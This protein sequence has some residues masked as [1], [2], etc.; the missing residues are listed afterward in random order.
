MG[1]RMRDTDRGWQK[2]KA[3]IK[4]LR[5]IQIAVGILDKGSNPHVGE[6]GRTVLDV[7]IWNEFGT[8][9]GN[10][11]IRIPARSFI[12]AWY[13]ELQPA[14]KTWVRAVGRNVASGKWSADRA[15]NLLGV[16]AVASIQARMSR[17]IEPPNAPSTVKQKGSSKPLINKGQL[18]SSVTYQIRKK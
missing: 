12:R 6:A 16:R 18:R 17:G 2:R 1:V 9:S 13:D 7:A 11:K 14:L 15:A 10:G 8:A 4:S 3:D 5:G